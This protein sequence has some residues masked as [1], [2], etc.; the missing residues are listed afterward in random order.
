MVAGI[1]GAQIARV[2]SHWLGA[3]D[4][5]EIVHG[6][7]VDDLRDVPQLGDAFINAQ[8]LANLAPEGLLDRLAICDPAA[9]QR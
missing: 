5:D 3:E 4:Q 6:V 2:A 7:S 8:F 9:G 1:D